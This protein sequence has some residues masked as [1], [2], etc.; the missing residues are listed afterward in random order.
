MAD[1]VDKKGKVQTNMELTPEERM[2]LKLAS[3]DPYAHGAIVGGVRALIAYWEA[4][5]RPS[6]RPSLP[7]ATTATE[8]PVN[9]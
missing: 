6:L 9:G 7:E 3:G 5:G 8:K 4:L 1:Y 2:T